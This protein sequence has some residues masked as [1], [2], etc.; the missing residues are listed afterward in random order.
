VSLSAGLHRLSQIERELR[1]SGVRDATSDAPRIELD[2]ATYAELDQ[3]CAALKAAGAEDVE[4]GVSV[5]LPPE[6]LALVDEINARTERPAG[7]DY[8]PREAAEP[9]ADDASP[10]STL[11]ERPGAPVSRGVVEA[12]RDARAA[13]RDAILTDG[14]SGAVVVELAFLRRPPLELD[15]VE[16]EPFD[17][18]PPDAEIEAAVE[19]EVAALATPPAPSPEPPTGEP[20]EPAP[21]RPRHETHAPAVFAWES[22]RSHRGRSH[23]AGI[24][25][26]E[27]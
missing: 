24:L 6:I 25:R 22:E 17:V 21:S 26:R 27:F 2:F 15:D 23:A 11:A 20:P 18:L 7:D 5:E 9:I 1:R 3:L 8:C 14:P 4:E 12:V 19:A 10:E 16:V 13:G